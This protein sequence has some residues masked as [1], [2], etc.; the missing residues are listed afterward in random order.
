MFQ[1]TGGQRST[2]FVFEKEDDVSL[3]ATLLQAECE[4]E[5]EYI[6]TETDSIVEL[7]KTHKFNC[8]LHPSGAFVTPMNMY[9]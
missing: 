8:Y 9:L 3:F 2:I 4:K 5:I 7:C 1:D 6:K